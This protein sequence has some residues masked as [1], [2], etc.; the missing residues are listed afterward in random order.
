MQITASAPGK[1]ILSGEHAVVYGCPALVAASNKRCEIAFE[2]EQNEAFS[3]EAV[4]KAGKLQTL[5][6]T[7]KS[8]STTQ[9]LQIRSSIP[10]GRGRGSS[11]ACSVAGAAIIETLQKKETLDLEAVNRFAYEMEKLQHGK[12]SG[13]DNTIVTY[14]GFLWYRKETPQFSTWKQVNK[15]RNLDSLYLVDSGK[16]TESTGDMVKAVAARKEAQTLKYAQIFQE[17][18]VVTRGFLRWILAESNESLLDLIRANHR[19][20]TLIEVVSPSTQKFIAEI[21][22]IGGAAKITGAGGWS[23]GSGYLLVYHEDQSKLEA[24]LAKHDK[25][26]QPLELGA[27]GVKV[28]SIT[29]E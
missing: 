1:V 28:E 19:L 16:P 15:Q 4:T 14:G 27:E 5:F 12:P 24:L 8:L 23:E 17:F 20:L 18:E 25:K 11:A 3:L 29:V 26:L 21:E 2:G 22:A 6:E 13:V 10:G 7:W 9:K